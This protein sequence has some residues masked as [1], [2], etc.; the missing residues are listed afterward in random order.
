MDRKQA[1]K[2]VGKVE[3]KT[4][5]GW[6]ESAIRDLLGQPDLTTRNPLPGAKPLRLFLRNRVI[7][8]EN[9]EEFQQYSGNEKK[10]ARRREVQARRLAILQ[11]TLAPIQFTVRQLDPYTLFERAVAHYTGSLQGRKFAGTITRDS[12][13]AFLRRIMVNYL[14]HHCTEYEDHIASAV[15]QGLKDEGFPIIRA[16]VYQ[17]I[18]VAYPE[19][20]EECDRQEGIRKATAK[21]PVAA[22]ASDSV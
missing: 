19:L 16:K 4:Q 18:R 22:V 15:R 10:Q 8:I 13:P 2:Y 21:T 11:E 12:D 1:R 6:T 9:S 14:R 5:R 17:A 20:A 3:L 7:A